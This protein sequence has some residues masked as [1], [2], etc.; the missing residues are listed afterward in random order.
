LVHL[1]AQDAQVLGGVCFAGSESVSRVVGKDS[2]SLWQRVTGSVGG[3][4]ADV[5]P[6]QRNILAH[7]G[8][9]VTGTGVL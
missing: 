9:Q 2:G 7:A 6:E 4:L 8:N 3:Q 1:L 5:L